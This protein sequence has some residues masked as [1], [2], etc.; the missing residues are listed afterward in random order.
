MN[1]RGVIISPFSYDADIKV[2]TLPCGGEL[3]T[4]TQL[5]HTLFFWDKIILPKTNFFQV[6]HNNDDLDYLET[7]GIFE[8]PII[9]GTEQVNGCINSSLFFQSDEI[10]LKEKNKQNP[11]NWSIQKMDPNLNSDFNFN[12]GQY[13]ETIELDLYKAIP[14]PHCDVPLEDILNFK[15]KYQNELLAFRILMLEM[16]HEIIQSPDKIV[17]KNIKLLKL[18]KAL[19]DLHKSL[20]AESIKKSLVSQKI[21]LKL[22]SSD[23]TNYPIKSYGYYEIFEKIGLPVPIAITIAGIVGLCKIELKQNNILSDLPSELK[24][25]AYIAKIEQEFC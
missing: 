3:I 6:V 17:A 5:R 7:C 25:Y 9:E 1:E 24:D 12:T 10:L 11:G 4:N 18:E 23:L 19:S 2:K 15:Q 16:Y 14:I 22:D 13:Q 8:Q 20:N 21:I